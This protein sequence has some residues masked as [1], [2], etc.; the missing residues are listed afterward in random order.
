MAYH[1]KGFYCCMEISEHC[2]LPDF[3]DISNVAFF[4]CCSFNLCYIDNIV[5]QV[6]SVAKM[7]TIFFEYLFVYRR[8]IFVYIFINYSKRFKV[9][10][11][12]NNKSRSIYFRIFISYRCVC[13]FT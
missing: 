3:T 8:Y 6:N 9:K 12:F 13:K 11:H 5:G 1:R 2:K 4:V 10:T 7:H